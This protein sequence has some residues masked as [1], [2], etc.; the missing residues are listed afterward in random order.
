MNLKS[1]STLSFAAI[2][3]LSA[4]A[5]TPADRPST[6][7]R[8]NT[9]IYTQQI[10]H[11]GPG[12]YSLKLSEKQ[13]LTC[14]FSEPTAA[15][16]TRAECAA[17]FPVTWKLIDETHAQAAKL[18]ISQDTSGLL[19]VNASQKPLITVRMVPTEITGTAEI[20]G[21]RVLLKENEARF[22]IDSDKEHE[23]LITPDSYEAIQA[24]DSQNGSTAMVST[25]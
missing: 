17:T 13:A 5:C 15:S 9:P 19:Q 4:A 14:A 7:A 23:V 8:Q 1:A 16:P 10:T 22:S 24:A 25:T 20:A 6:L 12:L 3:L 2:F 21:M 11:Y 18:I